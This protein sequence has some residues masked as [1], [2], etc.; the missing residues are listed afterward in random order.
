MLHNLCCDYSIR[1]LM[2]NK[3]N[4]CYENEIRYKNCYDMLS[5]NT[6][7]RIKNF[8]I[9]EEIDWLRKNLKFYILST[10]KKI[11]V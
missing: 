8:H 9:H 7:Q 6:E 5:E 1:L 11:A 2:K 3:R 10:R 4:I